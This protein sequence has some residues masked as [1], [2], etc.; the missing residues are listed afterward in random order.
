MENILLINKPSGITSYDVIRV[1]KR[2]YNPGKI[3]HAGTLDPLASGLLIVLIG[4]ATKES[5]KFMSLKK[6]YIVKI[7]LGIKTDTGDLE[8]KVINKL[9]IPVLNKIKIEKVLKKFKGKIKQIPHIY[10]AIKY[11]GKKLYEYARAGIQVKIKPR[12]IEIYR[13]KILNYSTKEL[14]LE[15]DCSK[16]TYIRKLAEDIAE[17]LGTCGVVSKLIREKIGK[18]SIAD[19]IKLDNI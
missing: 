3:G 11:K 6:R 2:K 1:I 12:I 18:Y 8:G 14:E 15:V 5:E 10:S 4:A 13:I 17:K 16:G 19:S 7:Q 9:E